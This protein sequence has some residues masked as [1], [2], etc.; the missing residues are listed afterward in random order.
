[1]A[2]LD[3]SK[4]K[5]YSSPLSLEVAP[6]AY[7]VER[8][9]RRT[10]A[11]IILAFLLLGELGLSWD[12]QWHALIG[13]DR[14]WTPPHMLI[15][16][17]IGGAGLVSLFVVFIETLRYKYPSTGVNEQS[18]IGMFRIFRAPLGF[19]VCGWGPMICLIAAPFDN[20]WHQLYG[21]DITLWA[22][23]HIMGTLGGILAGIGLI[24]AFASEAVIDRQSE[25]LPRTFLGLSA[26]EWGILILLGAMLRLTLS[27]LT[28]FPNFTV[29][30]FELL[31]YPLPLAFGAGL[32]I[33]G[34]IRCIRIRY[35]ITI[36]GILATLHTLISEAFVP[37]AIRVFV[38]Q[39][40]LTYR[41][42]SHLPFFNVTA[43]MLPI[44]FIVTGLVIDSIRPSFKHL[45]SIDWTKRIHLLLTVLVIVPTVLVAM[46]IVQLMQNVLPRVYIYMPR[47]QLSSIVVSLPLALAIGVV[48][49]MCGDMLGKVW[50]RNQR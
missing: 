17:A 32:C 14:F 49:T 25:R 33:I 7:R 18:T 3:T 31:T 6:Q 5:S 40:H 12:T 10:C 15:Y 28:Q 27:A 41:F 38:T 47:Q 16:T 9:F 44:A 30:P 4:Y 2:L 36:L 1:M 48:A 24:C 11:W 20:Y 22:P 13:R 23:F 8:V 39:S 21:I 42:P 29:G 43:V 35:S 34:C 45:L 19:V 46:L 50:S 26:S 37:W